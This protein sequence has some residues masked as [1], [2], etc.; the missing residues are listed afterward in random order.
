MN[1]EYTERIREYLRAQGFKD[2]ELID[3]LTDHLLIEVDALI[4]SKGVDFNSAFE[5][6]KTKILP[7][8]PYELER[9]LKLLTTQKN[10]IMIKKIAYIGAYL[11]ALVSSPKTSTV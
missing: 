9:D 5:E 7:D 6:A 2:N 11:S 10:N 1:R 8:N 3:D 4:E